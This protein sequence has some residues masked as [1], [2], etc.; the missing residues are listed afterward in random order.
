MPF[1]S[2]R[3][4]WLSGDVRPAQHLGRQC[5]EVENA[6]A[7]VADLE[8]EDG[9]IEFH[10]VKGHMRDD[11]AVKLKVAAVL[12]SCYVFRVAFVRPGGR[13]DVRLVTSAGIGARCEE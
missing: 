12:H 9:A 11:A 2:E 8:L 5:V 1:E 7:T 6:T 10:E 4:T 13:F 3:W